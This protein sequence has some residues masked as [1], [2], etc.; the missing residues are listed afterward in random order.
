MKIF[1]V[2]IMVLVCPLVLAGE[3]PADHYVALTGA[4]FGLELA[5]GSSI[6][7]TP[8]VVEFGYVFD[9]PAEKECRLGLAMP[10]FAGPTWLNFLISEDWQELTGLS[11]GRSFP[12]TWKL[13]QSKLTLAPAISAGIDLHGGYFGNAG[14]VIFFGF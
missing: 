1:T 6:P 8:L 10:K 7:Q 14:I 13:G 5:L 11:L 2:L 12:S 9:G 3:V 4:N